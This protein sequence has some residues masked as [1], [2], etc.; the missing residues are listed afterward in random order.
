VLLINLGEAREA[1]AHV[2]KERRYTATVL[3]DPDGS[4]AH[5]YGVHATPTVFLIS[6]DFDLVA[7]A[8]GSRPWAEPA[9]RAF[10]GA[11]LGQP[12]R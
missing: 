7:R 10:L 9:G 8:L 1:V 3:L 4:A 6:R 2:V 12:A 11:L 5:A